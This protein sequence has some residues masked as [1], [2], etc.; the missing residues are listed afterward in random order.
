MGVLHA[1][2]EV[3][4]RDTNVVIATVHEDVSLRGRGGTQIGIF[5]G[6]H[7]NHNEGENRKSKTHLEQSR[8]Q[9]P[10]KQKGS[11]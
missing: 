10:A 1:G 3:E 5:M 9:V 6:R 4:V 7:S 8:N 11:L 2:R